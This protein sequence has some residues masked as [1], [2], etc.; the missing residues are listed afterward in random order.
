MEGNDLQPS[1]DSIP[2]AEAPRFRP[3]HELIVLSVISMEVNW[4]ALWFRILT[5]TGAKVSFWKALAVLGGM[6]LGAYLLASILT[7]LRIRLNISRGVLAAWLAATVLLG[8]KLFVYLGRPAGAG[9]MV[10]GMIARFQSPGGALPAEFLVALAV[11]WIWWRGVSMAGI[12]MDSS[13]VIRRFYLGA[14][15]LAGYGLVAPI[16]GEKLILPVY[17]FLFSWLSAMSA[18]RI[19]RLA[20]FGRG[21]SAAFNRRWLAGVISAVAVVVALAALAGSLMDWK[22]SGLVVILVT[23]LGRAFL[24]VV[25]ALMSP[26]ILLLSLLMPYLQQWLKDLPDSLAKVG[27]ALQQLSRGVEELQKTAPRELPSLPPVL[28][29]AIFWGILAAA[30]FL[31]AW[32]LQKRYLKSLPGG[33]AD[34]ETILGGSELLRQWLSTLRSGA[35]F[36]AGQL[37]VLGFK[38]GRRFLAAA[39]IRRIYAQLTELSADL[40]R[41]RPPAFTPLEYLP[42]LENVFPNHAAELRMVTLAYLKVRYGELPETRQEVAQVETAWKRV[43][44]QGRVM[45]DY[46]RAKDHVR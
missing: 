17:L 18:A 15:M 33:E 42:V 1:P 28:R 36:L 2:P 32:A 14:G 6:L 35:Q 38:G 24:I 11:T 10:A 16:T 43:R 12:E 13:Q 8:L 25:A 46:Q 31:A 45:L 30:I 9:E 39:R 34:P 23:W 5:Q 29:A 44:E 22:L 7:A 4:A 20:R 3:W 41:P 37:G 27:E 21:Q 40:G 19:Y 26:M